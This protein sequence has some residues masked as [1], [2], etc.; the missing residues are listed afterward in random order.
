MIRYDTAVGVQTAPG[1]FL[2]ANA[3]LVP[4]NT[5]KKEAVERERERKKIQ[6][7]IRNS[8]KGTTNSLVTSVF[9]S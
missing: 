1:H 5:F 9:F 6:S 8:L 2:K 7:L 3:S 4:S